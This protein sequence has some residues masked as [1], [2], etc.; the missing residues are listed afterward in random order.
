[1]LGFA[2]C[3]FAI[4][5]ARPVEAASTETVSG[6]CMYDEAYEVL[7]IVNQKR[8]NQ[9][10]GKLTMDKDLL[11]AAMLR[12]AELTVEYNHLR[13]NGERCFTAC[14]KM[15]AENIAYGYGSAADV[16]SGW[17]GSGGHKTNIMTSEFN[18]I[19]VGCF[20]MNGVLY[21]VQCFGCCKAD[22]VSQPAN[23]KK[24][25]KV[26][27]TSGVETKLVNPV[28]SKVSGFTATAGKNK[29]TLKWKKK[30]SVDGYQLQISTTKS[31]S[32][33]RSFTIGKNTTKKV[34]KKYNGV[35]LKSKKR[36][37]VRIRAYVNSTDSEGN[38]VKKYS[39]WNRISKK[40][41]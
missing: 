24:T 33:K 35:K 39:K 21:W 25:Y 15:Y 16:M 38:T 9:G 28:G 4:L 34:I 37:Y 23:V 30:T 6:T 5:C 18:S 41:K 22:S 1:M 17:M 3:L 27:L 29:L 8:T 14:D 19:G 32:K 7:K 11:A 20:Q 40:T 12:A 10:L 26:S 31:F 36:Y 13:P 2:I